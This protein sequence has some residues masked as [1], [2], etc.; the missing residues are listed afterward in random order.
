MLSCL[1]YS[2]HRFENYMLHVTGIFT[3]MTL[4]DCFSHSFWS[5]NKTYTVLPIG[6]QPMGWSHHQHPPF[7]GWRWLLDLVFFFYRL[8]SPWD[9]VI[10]IKSSPPKL[11]EYWHHFSK[12][13]KYLKQIQVNC[14]FSSCWLTLF[15]CLFFLT[16]PSHYEVEISTQMSLKYKVQNAF[17]LFAP[18]M[19]NVRCIGVQ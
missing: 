3:H 10:T 5:V 17:T 18:G 13:L 12:H 11:E 1:Q 19:M 4:I 8:G 15:C 7:G 2:C 6:K 14:S 16:C 9:E